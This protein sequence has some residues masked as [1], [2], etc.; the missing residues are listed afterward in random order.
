MK[1]GRGFPAWFTLRH[2][3]LHYIKNLPAKQELRIQTPGRKDSLEK[4]MATHSCI[5]LGKSQG[6]RSLADY[7]PWGCEKIRYDFVTK[8]QRQ[9][10]TLTPCNTSAEEEANLFS[11]LSH[12]FQSLCRQHHMVLYEIAAFSFLFTCTNFDSLSRDENPRIRILSCI[13]LY[14]SQR[15]VFFWTECDVD[16]P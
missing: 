11:L 12:W 8:Q 16:I 9:Q 2:L 6:Q 7:S 14:S 13:S 1:S 10:F 15:F 4:E 5:L 3:W